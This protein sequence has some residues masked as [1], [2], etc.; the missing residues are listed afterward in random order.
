MCEASLGYEVSSKTTCTRRRKKTSSQKS[1]HR[2]KIFNKDERGR[3]GKQCRVGEWG[4]QK[5]C[6]RDEQRDQEGSSGEQHRE[7]TEEMGIWVGQLSQRVR[8]GRWAT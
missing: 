5:E 4:S 2:L 8:V 1:V 3:K 6:H 7:V